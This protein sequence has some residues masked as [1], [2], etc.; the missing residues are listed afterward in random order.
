MPDSEVREIYPEWANEK[1]VMY[2]WL[3]AG[4]PTTFEPFS[5]TYDFE[6]N[7]QVDRRERNKGGDTDGDLIPFITDMFG[8]DDS[9]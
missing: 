9:Q 6:S 2:S 8:S 7:S 5:K 1:D 4:Y 3:L